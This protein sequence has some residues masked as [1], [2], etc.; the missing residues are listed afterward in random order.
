M[1][2]YG[3]LAENTRRNERVERGV[4]TFTGSTQV[5]VSG[6]M[7]LITQILSLVQRGLVAPALTPAV[8]TYSGP[9]E[10]GNAAN[11]FKIY[12]WMPTSSTAPAL[13]A[14]TSAVTVSWAVI[15]N[16]SAIAGGF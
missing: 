6:P 12:S 8:L 14:G 1:S 10:D 15:G 3:A 5:T 16:L 2:L 7:R 9:N 13:I 11:Q 4:V